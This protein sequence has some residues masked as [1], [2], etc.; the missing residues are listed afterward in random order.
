MYY[1]SVINLSQ[2]YQINGIIFF[3]KKAF[4]SDEIKKK[5]L[6]M[7]NTEGVTKIIY[8]KKVI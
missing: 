1:N 3:N 4:F 6:S 2:K 5:A 7:K 8:Q